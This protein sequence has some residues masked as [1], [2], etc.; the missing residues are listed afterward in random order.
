MKF[1]IVIPNVIVLLLFDN[2]PCP[3]F[4]K[5]NDADFPPTVTET[6]DVL[7][8]VCCNFVSSVP[9]KFNVYVLPESFPLFIEP[10]HTGGVASTENE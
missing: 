4:E 3:L 10:F 2:C 6:F 5:E 1:E 7:N 9:I 8:V